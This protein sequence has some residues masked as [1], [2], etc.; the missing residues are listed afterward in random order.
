MIPRAVHAFREQLA[1]LGYVEGSTLH[2]EERWANGDFSRLDGLANQLIQENVDILVATSTQDVRA[3]KKA[4]STI[5]IVLN[6]IACA[7]VVANDDR[8]VRHVAVLN[9]E[10]SSPCRCSSR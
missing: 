4:T 3:A 2:I 5:P 10:G 1:H 7:G 8:A 9:A 6:Q